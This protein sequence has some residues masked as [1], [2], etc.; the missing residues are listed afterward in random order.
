MFRNSDQVV[1]LGPGDRDLAE[2]VLKVDPVRINVVPNA[3]PAPPQSRCR[4]GMQ[5]SVQILFSGNPS[6][7]KGLHD[8]IAALKLEPIRNLDWKLTVAGGGNETAAFREM[9]RAAGLSDRIN[10][11]GWVDRDKINGLLETADILVLPSYAEGMAMSV[12]EGMSYG[13]CIV[14]T[15]V[16]SLRD[17]IEDEITGLIVQ[18]GEVESLAEALARAAKD[19]TLRAR[20]GN[21]AAAQFFAHFDAAN[22]PKRMLPIYQA[23]FGGAN[24]SGGI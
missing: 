2:A 11:T 24:V 10:F 21:A 5:R 12:L 19:P 13:L 14:C 7:R 23:A 15:P 3:V 22:Y 20:V 16:G 17:V 8:L 9:A 4:A 6:R 1:V 18:P